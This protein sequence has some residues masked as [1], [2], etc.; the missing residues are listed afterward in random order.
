[1]LE[2]ALSTTVF[3]AG[4]AIPPVY[5]CV[6]EDISPPLT[7]NEAPEGTKSIAV[8]CDDPDAPIGTWSHWVLFNLPPETTELR[9]GMPT[10]PELPNGAVQGMNDFGR[11]G[12]GGPCPP[13]GQQHR[14]Y[15]KVFALD[16]MLPL[17]EQARSADVEQAME[18][19]ILARGEWM[20]TFKK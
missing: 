16:T 17:D 3:A 6:G 12:Y 14:Y 5:T 15:F 7:W 19:H 1:M 13:H 4:A 18:G 11:H 9:E 20:G 2:L 8:L 10:D